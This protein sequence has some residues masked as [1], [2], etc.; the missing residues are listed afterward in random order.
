MAIATGSALGTVVLAGD[1]AG[2]MDPTGPQLA[3]TGVV[4][5]QYKG[6]TVVVDA[7]GRIVHARKLS[8]MDVPCADTDTCGIV[9][10]GH[11]I[12][13][14]TVDDKTV[15]SL[16]EGSKDDFGVVKLGTGFGKDCCEIYVD[17]PEATS[18]ARGGVYAPAGSTVK[19]TPEA[20]L[21]IAL[22]TSSAPGV[23][24]VTTGAGLA[25]TGSTLS[26][27]PAQATYPNATTTG[28]GVVS[29][30]TANGLTIANGIATLDGIGLPYPNATPTTKGIVSIPTASGLSVT[31]AV[32]SFN[33]LL[34]TYPAATT[35]TKGLVTVGSSINVASG[36]ISVPTATTSVMGQI[37]GDADFQVTAG[38]LSYQK[39]ATS[40]VMGYVKAGAGMGVSADGTLSRGAANGDATDTTKGVVQ[41]GAGLSVSAGL[42]SSGAATTSVI[43]QIRGDGT[44][45]ITSGVLS[46]S[47]PATTSVLGLVKVGSGVSID[48]AGVLTRTASNANATTS[49]KGI[50]Q[51]GAGLDV[52]AGVISTSVA[53]TT[54]RGAVKAGDGFVMG[55]GATENVMNINMASDGTP[56][57]MS[58]TSSIATTAN[59]VIT[60]NSSAISSLA[61]LDQLNV[62]TARNVVSSVGS[63]TGG[64]VAN[65]VLDGTKMNTLVTAGS[66]TLNMGN[67]TISGSNL[68]VGTNHKIIVQHSGGNGATIKFNTGWKY[69]STWGSNNYTSSGAFTVINALVTSSTQLMVT[70]IT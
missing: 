70:S 55:F 39:V 42:I 50:V 37:R 24:S 59:G 33:G 8:G 68:V 25:L 7:K 16:K 53:S 4:P 60:I 17:Y 21:S 14:E 49:S 36:N 45:A 32:A 34:A 30:P 1:L 69:P 26:F 22:G 46:Q 48:G 47:T 57:L 19:M 12:D 15:I 66:A 56:G 58:T 9:K 62:F 43:G 5:G 23:V 20:E 11:F 28:L 2:G 52:S 40:S 18:T 6:A 64:G 38:T 54:A 51:V 44:F 31:G 61:K 3:P 35:S 10:I 67:G 63:P 41:I 13:S 27:V 29:V 65:L